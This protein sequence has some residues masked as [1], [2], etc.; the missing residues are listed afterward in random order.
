MLEFSEIVLLITFSV[1][2]ILG[3]AGI[4]L[5]NRGAA[6]DAAERKARRYSEALLPQNYD[7]EEHA[8]WINQR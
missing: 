4:A 7:V 3:L 1:F 2:G 5:I 8:A 6:K